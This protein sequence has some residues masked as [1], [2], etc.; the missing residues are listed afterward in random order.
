[1]TFACCVIRTWR[2]RE[3]TNQEPKIG[4]VRSVAV[5]G[6]IHHKRGGFRAKTNA[7]VPAPCDSRIQRGGLAICRLGESGLD[8]LVDG[9][10]IGIG[11]GGSGEFDM[12]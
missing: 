2:E 4:S 6:T 3:F 11:I 7:P 1:M 9:I 5:T 10:G 12:L 8:K